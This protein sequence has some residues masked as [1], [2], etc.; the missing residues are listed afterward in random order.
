MKVYTDG[1]C[2]G[3][4]GLGGWGVYIEEGKQSFSGRSPNTTNNIM[5]LTAIIRALEIT[6]GNTGTLEILADSEYCL[7]GITEWIK[8]WKARN[9]VTAAKQ[10]VKNKELWQKL[11]RLV[12]GHTMTVVFTKVKAHCG[13]YG[14]E[15]AD[16]LAG[17][18][19]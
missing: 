2:K 18:A 7:K 10:P 16:R 4:P 1:A 6:D 14:N 19:T 15:M 5:E 3:N 17:G 9:W 8:G 11:D 13:I 12:T